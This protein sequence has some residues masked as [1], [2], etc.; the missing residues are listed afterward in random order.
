MRF[1]AARTTTAVVGHVF[2]PRQA[3]RQL[4]E[5]ACPVRSNIALPLPTLT[6]V[7]DIPAIE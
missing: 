3:S 2:F 7:S 6:S 1:D 4:S 5:F